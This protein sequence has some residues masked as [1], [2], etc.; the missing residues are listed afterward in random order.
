MAGM[1]FVLA[2]DAGPGTARG[3]ND[4]DVVSDDDDSQPGSATVATPVVQTFYLSD[5]DGDGVLG[6][7][8][9]DEP[10]SGVFDPHNA[11]G[12]ACPDGWTYLGIHYGNSQ[13]V[14]CMLQ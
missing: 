3:S 2:C 14:V 6:P 8:E 9:W 1:L 11:N 13:E 10:A 12:R 4:D 5:V 7:N